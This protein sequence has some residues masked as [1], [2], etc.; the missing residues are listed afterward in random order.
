MKILLDTHILVW[1]LV[2]DRRLSSLD[3]ALILGS[4]TEILVSSLSIWKIRLKRRSALRRGRDSDMPLDARE[5]MA[6]CERL[7][8]R[9]LTPAPRDFAAVLRTPVPHRDSFDEM[10]VLHAQ[11]LGARLLTED[12]NLIDHPIAYRP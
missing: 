6:L 5:A 8:L 12:E 11:Q 7:A 9:L 4:D 2:E 1:L 10:L 3:A